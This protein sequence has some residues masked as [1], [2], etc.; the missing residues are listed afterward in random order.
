MFHLI[1]RLVDSFQTGDTFPPPL[2]ASNT[3]DNLW[4]P[5]RSNTLNVWRDAIVED[6]WRNYVASSGFVEVV[7]PFQ[8][9]QRRA[10]NGAMPSP[11]TAF[12]N[13]DTGLAP[14]SAATI[15]LVL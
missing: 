10:Q 2:D 14:G 6:M 12:D 11:S 9:A 15:P 4:S 3:S 13:A 8:R 1:V 5:L 7:T